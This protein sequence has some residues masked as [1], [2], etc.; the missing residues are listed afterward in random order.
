MHCPECRH[1]AAEDARFCA[2]CGTA[3]T[4]TVPD[5]RELRTVHDLRLPRGDVR[6]LHDVDADGPDLRDPHWAHYVEYLHERRARRARTT[7]RTVIA[8]IALLAV[9]AVGAAFQLTGGR[10]WSPRARRS[11]RYST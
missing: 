4:R 7:Q 2:Q 3:L 6:D 5:V 8:G 11:W 10:F 1:D 9:L